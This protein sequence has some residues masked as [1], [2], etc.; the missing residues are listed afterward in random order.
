MMKNHTDSTIYRLAPS[1][2]RH[3]APRTTLGVC[4]LLLFL[5]VS[6]PAAIVFEEVTSG[7]AV[8]DGGISAGVAWGD[9]NN[10]G[11]PD[12]FITNW[13]NQNNYL[14]RNDG[15]SFVKL[16]DQHPV[17][18]QA[19]SSGV[20]WGDY[21][22]DG[23]LDVYVA[24]QQN[25]PNRLFRNDGDGT[26][27]QVGPEGGD[28]AS[29]SGDSY[30]CAWGDYDSDG[31]LD[32]IVANSS[33]QANFLYHNEGDGSFTRITTGPVVTQYR[34]SWG[35]AWCDYNGDGNLDLFVANAGGQNN[36]LFRN[37]GGG[38]FTSLTT[39]PVVTDGLTSHG[40]SWADYDNDGD[41]DLYVANGP[42]GGAGN[43]DRLYR[44]DGGDNFADLT[45]TMVG[46]ATHR[47]GNGIWGDFNNDGLIDLFVT[48]YFE[49]CSLFENTGGGI[50]VLDGVSDIV[51]RS[52]YSSGAAAGDYDLDGDLDIFIA[53]WE[54]QRN[55]LWSAETG[56]ANWLR[57]QC[58]GT[59]SNAWGIGAVVRI[60]ATIESQSLVQ[61]RQITGGYGHRS[62]DELVACFGLGDATE[63]DSVIVSWPSG[64]T[65]V[66]TAVSLNHSYLAVEGSGLQC[67]GG[68]ADG[69]G[70]P[71][72]CDD[73]PG[74]DDLADADGDGVPDGCDQCPGHDDRADADDDGVADGCDLCEGHDDNVDSDGDTVPD[75]CDNCPDEPN[76]NQ[77]DVDS[78]TYGDLCDNCPDDFNP[79]QEDEDEDGIGDVCETCCVGRVG[80]ANGSGDDEPTI[81]D[82][83]LMIDA[84]FVAGDLSIIVCLPEAD[85]NQSGGPDP[86]P[87]DVTIG[88]ITML[89]DYLFVTGTTLGLP[90]CL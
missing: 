46:A 52:S 35:A 1:A 90:N 48:N 2:L 54:N 57:I 84:K 80:D 43:P 71:D 4:L 11:S 25:N 23:Y 45:F 36:N 12:L 88:D 42:Y 34:T 89:I 19:Y 49:N 9:F 38:V 33:N 85:A 50:L 62:Q 14:Y 27:T 78:D 20:C 26:F 64:V 41:F 63:V 18:T 8:N 39:G 3:P 81:G 24:N 7:I 77:S 87:E 22:N 70:V 31:Y 6:V 44:N 51:H 10:D 76:G 21:D 69:D 83:S 73:C 86:T 72:G 60:R 16:D 32:L 61:V 17:A 29:G 56:D 30:S 58:Q 5:P 82:I 67:T 37:D 40:G 28:I 47:S 65:D 13:A 74:F 75:G 66:F 79:G 59:S 68:D 55:F 53:N 15:G